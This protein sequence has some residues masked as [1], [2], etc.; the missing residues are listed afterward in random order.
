M[1]QLVSGGSYASQNDRR[2]HFGLAGASAVERLEIR[3]PDGAV[4]SYRDLPANRRYLVKRG[5]DP[6]ELP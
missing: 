3:W 4:E 5:L 6:I 2:L 1:R